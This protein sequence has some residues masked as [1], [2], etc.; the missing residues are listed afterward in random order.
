MTKN[1]L[2]AAAT[3]AAKQR[4]TRIGANLLSLSVVALAITPSAAGSPS[5]PAETTTKRVATV[6][7]VTT[8]DFRVA[9]VAQRL[10]GGATPTAEVRVAIAQ[11]IAN[12]WRERSETRLN[13]TYF[14]QPVTG[15][16]A[17]CRLDVATATSPTRVPH[18]AVQ[19]LRTPSL[20][21]GPLHR[22]RLPAR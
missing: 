12:R 3:G 11:R 5:H 1:T 22:F 6:A 8:R 9:V 18:V 17:V 7:I 20:G 2:P 13:E 16:R 21:C 4:R 14:W 15:P 19:L 10:D